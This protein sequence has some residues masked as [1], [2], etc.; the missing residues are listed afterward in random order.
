[1]LKDFHANN[2]SELL[3]ALSNLIPDIARESKFVQRA[4][5]AFCPETFLLALLN[6]VSSGK[7][8]LHQI[9][10]QLDLN[11]DHRTPSPQAIHE[12]IHRTEIGIESFLVRCLAFITSQKFS[13]HL[14]SESPFNRILVEDSTQLALHVHNAE[15]FPANGNHLGSTAGCK[16]DICF[17]LLTGQTITTDLTTATTQDKTIGIELL[18]HIQPNDL[19]LRDMGYFS[20]HNFAKI[21]AT[22]AYWLS[23]VPGNVH[24]YNPEGTS[25]ETLLQQEQTDTLDLPIHLGENA[26]HP[27]RIVAK[28]CTTEESHRNRREVRASYR[29]RGKTPSRARLTRCDWHL[30]VTNIP[31]A[32]QTSSQLHEIYRQRWQ[33]ELAFRGW[34]KSHNLK[35]LHKHRTS[36]TH[37]K[38]LILAAMILLSLTLQLAKEKQQAMKKEDRAYFSMEKFFEILSQTIS[39]LKSLEEIL[40]LTID[41]RYQRSQKRSR[42]SLIYQQFTSLA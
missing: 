36:P 2:C 23:R 17:D 3:A 6:A 40:H 9:A 26:R 27:T 37:L 19:V 16:I 4:S 1:M 14:T 12:R 11:S 13:T 21:E 5:K 33:I 39:K 7:G 8:S 15:E 22:N 34:K 42:K 31:K 41:E 30:M 18:D 24:A 38:M 29:K 35:N 10:V 32:Q 20:I 25:I 28:K